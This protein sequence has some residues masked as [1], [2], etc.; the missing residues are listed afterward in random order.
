MGNFLPKK[1]ISFTSPKIHPFSNS[2]ENKE[3]HGLARKLIYSGSKD[4]NSIL[5][6]GSHKALHS[7]LKNNGNLPWRK[8]PRELLSVEQFRALVL[9]ECARCDRNSHQFSLVE[10]ELPGRGK[11][12]KEIAV[13][14][15]R[16]ILKRIRATDEA[17][18][19]GEKSLGVFLPETGRAGAEIFAKDVFPDY[20]YQVYTYPDIAPA[21]KAAGDCPSERTLSWRRSQRTG[22]ARGNVPDGK[23]SE[24][25][26]EP[27]TPARVSITQDL[28]A[29]VHPGGAPWWKRA[30]DIT[31]ASIILALLSPLF[32]V[33]AA[34]IKMVSPGPVF[35]RQERVGYLGRP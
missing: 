33:V 3:N 16:K 32:L 14:L 23:D 1:I 21:G 4:S 2:L 19:L 8:G 15:A 7:I 11:D 28:E 5:I 6:T 25:S 12:K 22:D 10:V 20:A 30:I 29:V 9:H 13:S 18:W 17:G 27:A 34:Y 31:G 24:H 26:V 35:F